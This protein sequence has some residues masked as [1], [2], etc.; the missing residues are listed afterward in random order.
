MDQEAEETFKKA[1]EVDPRVVYVYNR[2]GIALRKQG[3]YLEAIGKYKKALDIDPEDYNVHY[4]LGRA[5]MEASMISDAK[6]QF[7]EAARI[8]PD[9]K[10]AKTLLQFLKEMK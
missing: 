6:K 9:F 7:K 2:L 5:Y 3:K 4:N 1:L 8:N 10:E